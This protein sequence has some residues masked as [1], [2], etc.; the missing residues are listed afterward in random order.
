MGTVKGRLEE[1][2]ATFP[3]AEEEKIKMT[4]E[5]SRAVFWEEAGKL[6]ISY[7]DFLYQQVGYIRKRWWGLQFLALTLLWGCIY[8]FSAGTNILNMTGIV[9]GLFGV[10]L[11]PELWKNRSC[12]AMEVEGSTYYSLRQ[13]YAARM[14]AFGVVD[15][16]LLSVF[17]LV[18]SVTTSMRAEEMIIYF[19][20]PFTVTCGILFGTLCSR[21][22][23]SEAWAFLLALFWI[24]IWVLIVLNRQLY[25][26]ISDSVWM[27]LL[28]LAVCYLGYG[29]R[30]TLVRC[31]S[32]WEGSREW[33]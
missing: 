4:V 3:M 23:A 30:R 6:P 22:P 8:R 15:I 18:T 25:L 13:I 24:M 12:R 32:F 33:S 10:L 20:L 19:F 7:Q 21:Y 31:E 1:Y 11:I 26:K 29:I 27:A 28:G 9:A 14:L 2:A 16:G 17:T 5:R